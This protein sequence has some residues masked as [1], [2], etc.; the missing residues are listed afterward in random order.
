MLAGVMALHHSSILIFLS[1]AISVEGGI[2]AG[3]HR[4]D[5]AIRSGRRMILGI[6][7]DIDLYS[8]SL[9]ETICLPV[10]TKESN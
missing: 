2:I 8:L 5:V 3:F 6:L 4:V 10:A 7:Q 9:I 1:V